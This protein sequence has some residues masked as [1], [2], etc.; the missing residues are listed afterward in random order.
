MT[1]SPHL[2]ALLGVVSLLV[3]PVLSPY[4]ARA[5]GIETSLERISTLHGTGGLEKLEIQSRFSS[6]VPT[7]DASVRLL[8][9]SGGDPI[10]LGHTGADGRLRF[11]LPAVAQAGGEIQ[12]DAGPGHRDYLDLSDLESPGLQDRV[13]AS[14]SRQAALDDFRPVHAT[15]ALIGLGLVGGAGLWSQR[16]RKG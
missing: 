13:P 12:V 3:I 7:Q 15:T 9:A 8:P 14:H 10:E 1:R 2:K 5:H 16:R 6:G 4:P 11:D